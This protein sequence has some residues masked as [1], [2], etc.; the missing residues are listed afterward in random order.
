MSKLLHI[1][2]S[3]IKRRIISMM[4][5]SLLLILVGAII[6]PLNTFR[7]VQNYDEETRHLRE[8]QQYVTSIVNHTNEIILRV[9]G[10]FAYLDDY[11]YEQI[12]VAKKELEK[13]IAAFKN[14]ELTEEELELI[15][16]IEQYFDNYI[17]N[18]LPKGAAFAKV[19]DYTSLRKLIT[20]GEN[21]P[22]ND[23]IEYAKQSEE[24]IRG[25]LNEE[26]EKLFRTLLL[27]GVYLMGYGVAVLI[28]SLLITRR[29]AMDIGHPLQRLSKHAATYA[30]AE[31]ID[32][33]MLDRPDEIG[34]LSRSLNKM[35]YEIR[36]KEEELLA[37]NE[38]LQAQQDELQAQQDELQKVLGQMEENEIYLNKRNMLT[39]SLTSKL[40]QHQLME[41]IIR[42][43][44]EITAMDKGMLVRMNETLDY[45][46]YGLS[47][48]EVRQL[49]SGFRESAAVRA[50]ESGKLFVREREATE[51]EKGYLLGNLSAYDV[52]VPLYKGNGEAAA[53]LILTR[54]GKA[55]TKREEADLQGLA[56]SISLS[57]DKL[58]MYETSE[59]ERQLTQVM[60]NT[61]QEGVQL[62][63]LDGQSLRVNEKLYELMGLPYEGA[64]LNGAG[65]SEFKKLLAARV[66]DPT[67]LLSFIEGALRGTEQDRSMTYELATQPVRYIQ[68]YWEPIYRNNIPFGVLLVHR[69]MT[70]EYE[71]DRMKSEFVSTV[72][73]ELRTPLASILGF[74]EL[75]LHRELK[76]ERQ[77]KYVSTIHQ[78][79]SRLTQL[80]NDFLDLQRMESGK[81]F[82]EFK[83][84]DMYSLIGE[85]A[86]LQQAA[87]AKHTI[88]WDGPK[89]GSKVYG[90]R[91]KLL[92][93][94]VNLIGN[95]VKYSPGGGSIQLSASET[96][97][98][99]RIG[100]RDEG[101]GIPPQA[102]PHLFSKFYRVDNTDRREIGGTGLGLAI[103]KEIVQQHQGEISVES[104]LGEGSVFSIELPLYTRNN[105]RRGGEAV[106]SER[107]SGSVDVMLVENDHSL[108]LMLQDELVEQGYR[109][110][111]FMDGSSALKAMEAHPPDIVVLDLK[112]EPDLS[113]WEVI[114]KMKASN[115]LKDI[116]IV[117]S[118]AFEE[119]EKALQQG[120]AHFLIKPYVPYKLSESIEHILQSKKQ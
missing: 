108:S 31:S 18:L 79:A 84:V 63:S 57:L 75:M 97:G 105:E 49:I 65:F 16:R 81:Q 21:N 118:S 71:V 119:K 20:L 99:M 104:E 88:V 90:D 117:I 103:V 40:D 86:E 74:S 107:V 10:Y 13:S 85:V 48:E 106:P 46:S 12:F 60:L 23:I 83:P 112:L 98:R 36:E 1:V 66:E 64:E 25:Q 102:L 101:L 109:T 62:M 9:R 76:P 80:V 93:A 19:D 59:N 26:N 70:K 82:Y 116:P 42:N 73:H 15:V 111:V 38:E 6:V 8:S 30:K 34:L 17:N 54:T 50:L 14:T 100:I 37:Q 77:R 94:L 69:D 110:A 53:C 28:F 35:I 43:V 91:D 58:A 51:G 3:S 72:S 7:Y 33:T 114:G 56:G 44:A 29:L 41:S 52:F 92:Q 4:V 68:M 27:Q 22:T 24:L 55:V 113:G 45:A 47:E 87:T 61:I 11:E 39:Q 2:R 115:R 32:K 78:E 67:A 95:A 120:V 89:E 5:V 96:D